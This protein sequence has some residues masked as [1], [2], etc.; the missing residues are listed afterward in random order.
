MSVFPSAVVFLLKVTK[1]LDLTGIVLATLTNTVNIVVLSYF[2]SGKTDFDAF[3][4]VAR[5]DLLI[6]NMKNLTFFK[7]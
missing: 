7:N 2:R 1:N 3:C 6:I 5:L 4:T